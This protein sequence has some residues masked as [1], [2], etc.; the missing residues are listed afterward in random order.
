MKSSSSDFVSV[1]VIRRP[2]SEGCSCD[3]VIDDEYDKPEY[4]IHDRPYIVLWQYSSVSN[5]LTTTVAVDLLQL[6]SWIFL[7]L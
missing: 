7:F 2:I 5:S 6:S 3:N 1:A 4:C